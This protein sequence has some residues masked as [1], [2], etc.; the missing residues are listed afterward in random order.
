MPKTMMASS[1]TKAP[2]MEAVPRS[3]WERKEKVAEISRARKKM[4]TSHLILVLDFDPLPASFFCLPSAGA[5][6]PRASFC[7]ILFHRFGVIQSMVAAV[8]V[9][10]AA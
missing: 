4:V 6:P 8:R 10:L 1:T 9:N 7:F 3:S 2:N 5:L